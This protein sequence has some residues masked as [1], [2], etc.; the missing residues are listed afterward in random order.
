MP[1][2]RMAMMAYPIG[3]KEEKALSRALSSLTPVF[4]KPQ[5]EVALVPAAVV[6]IAQQAKNR[7]PMASAPPPG[8]QPAPPGPTPPPTIPGGPEG[9]S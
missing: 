7:G 5:D 4:A 9:E 8:I 2:I 1:L 3:S 6:D